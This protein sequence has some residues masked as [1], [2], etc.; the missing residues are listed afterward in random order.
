MQLLVSVR[1]PLEAQAALLGGAHIIDAKE[2]QAGALGAVPLDTLR[3]IVA[4]VR[5]VR[6]VTAA[7]GDGFDPDALARDAAAFCGAG[8]A[9]VKVGFGGIRDRSRVHALLGA[10]VAAV[11]RDRVIAV[12]YGDYAAVDSVSPTGM[13]DAAARCGVRGILAD[14]A[15]KRGQSLTSLMS[16]AALAKWAAAAGERGLQVGIAGRLTIA[17]VAS[18]SAAGADIVGVRGAACVGGRGGRVDVARVRALL[19]ACEPDPL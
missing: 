16:P 6:P 19:T 2:P 15:D 5:G 13:L 14:T 8:A 1:D 7:L 10:A 9:M 4:A 12:A 17:D 3:R 11:G 18:V